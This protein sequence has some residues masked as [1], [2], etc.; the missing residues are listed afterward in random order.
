M[1]A[2]GAMVSRIWTLRLAAA[3]ALISIAIP[4]WG[5]PPDC[6]AAKKMFAA[7]C[8]MC[9]MDNGTGNAALKSP[10][11]TDPKWQAA[12]KDPEL[13]A[14]ISNGVKGTSMPSWKSQL[15]PAEINAL[16]HCVV[17][18]FG[19]KAAPAQNASSQKR[20]PA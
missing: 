11:F 2:N 17:R 20:P 16:I 6:A 3:T 14:A 12:H 1:K 4:V 18:G 5:A 10:N 13:V 8:A 15:N 19:K 9:H 7:N